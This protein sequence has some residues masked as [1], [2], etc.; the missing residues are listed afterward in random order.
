MRRIPL[1]FEEAARVDGAGDL[2]I[3]LPLC[4]PALGTC[5]VFGFLMI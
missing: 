5:A 2:R 4:K 1:E 3:F